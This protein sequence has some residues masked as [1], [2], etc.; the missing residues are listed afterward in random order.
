MSNRP[1][2]LHH[3]NVPTTNPQRT[4]EWYSRV[5][6]LKRVY[7]ASNTKILLL[8]N[9]NF[10]LH[11]TPFRPEKFPRLKP[12]HFA[13]EVESWAGF[14]KHLDELGVYHTKTVER[15]QNNSKFCYVHDP[16]GNMIE[17]TYHGNRHLETA[18][19]MSA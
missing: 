11:F 9:G 8:T 19:L 2:C 15:P 18:E 3:T 6:G 13:I 14:M 5:F 10:D 16:D 12:L 1:Y 4:W 17:L 7:A